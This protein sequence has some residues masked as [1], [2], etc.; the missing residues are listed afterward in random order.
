MTEE[1]YMTLQVFDSEEYGH[2]MFV[3]INQHHHATKPKAK[4]ITIMS[5]Q[6][7]EQ[8]QAQL[9]EDIAVDIA[10]SLGYPEVGIRKNI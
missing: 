10:L 4:D 9:R 8:Q 2:V 6:F 1:K 5:P 7:D 3:D